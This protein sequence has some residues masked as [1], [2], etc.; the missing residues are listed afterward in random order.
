MPTIQSIND[1]DFV[2]GVIF[3]ESDALKGRNLK[4]LQKV[5]SVLTAD[6]GLVC[7]QTVSTV[8]SHLSFIPFKTPALQPSKRCPCHKSTAF[9]DIFQDNYNRTCWTDHVL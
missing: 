9:N 2:L 8:K 3:F 5:F 1:V 7:C 6:S 4:R